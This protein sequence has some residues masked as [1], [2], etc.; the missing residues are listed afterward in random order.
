M[1]LDL[2]RFI[3]KYAGIVICALLSLFRLV[4][5]LLAPQSK[6]EVKNILIVELSE[7]GSAILAYPMM[8]KTKEMYPDSNLYFLIFEKHKETVDLLGTIPTENILCISDSSFTEFVRTAWE[9]LA[10]ARLARIDTVLDCELFSRF[11]SIFSYLTGASRRLGFHN[12]LDEG[13]YRGSLLTHKVPY[14]SM[15][16]ISKNFLQLALATQAQAATIPPVKEKIS[17]AS[18]SLPRVDMSEQSSVYSVPAG[19]KLVLLNPDPGM[20]PLRGWPI[21][22]YLE[23]S[24]L[25][26]EHDSN[27][28]IGIIGLESSD[29]YYATFEENFGEQI[30]NFCGKTASLKSLLKLMESSA[31]LITADSGPAHLAPLV[32]L[33][34]IVL[35]GPES[36][37]RYKPLSNQVSA[38]SAGLAC[39]PC[40][41]A[42]NHR[43]SSCNFNACMHAITARS[44]FNKSKKFL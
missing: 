3:D 10:Q 32:E 2:I 28:I 1:S 25:L 39:S 11:T 35:F 31:L 7:M 44:V 18:Y 14:N 36:K 8:R 24:Q 33:P 15:E 19:K 29:S 23:L 17:L 27:I 22:N 38:V 26:I 20:L 16:H 13:L 43:S 41:S 40:F 6:S 12:Y 9:A 5:D 21:E 4:R 34:S 42:A 30:L 37:V